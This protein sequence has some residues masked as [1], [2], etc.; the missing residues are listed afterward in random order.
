MSRSNQAI[1]LQILRAPTIPLYAC[2]SA[3]FKPGL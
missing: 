2:I 1:E 3:S